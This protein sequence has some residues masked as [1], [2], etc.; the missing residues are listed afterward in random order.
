MSIH[1]VIT[2]F[3]CYDVIIFYIGVYSKNVQFGFSFKLSSLVILRIIKCLCDF[4]WSHF[5]YYKNLA[6][7]KPVVLH[8]GL[9]FYGAK[10]SLRIVS[11]FYCLFLTTI[12]IKCASF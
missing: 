3:S 4:S 12:L 1:V 9:L 5:S 6:F 11:I 2:A 8:I 7:Y 10:H